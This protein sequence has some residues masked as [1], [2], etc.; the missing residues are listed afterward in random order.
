MPLTALEKA[1]NKAAQLVRN[2]AH[3]AR[4]R[5]LEKAVED[6]ERSPEVQA[7]RA[8]FDD[9]DA[10]QTA[11]DSR[12]DEQIAGIQEQIAQLQAQIQSLRSDAARI[13]LRE[14]RSDAADA[15]RKVKGGKVAT[16][17]ALFPDLVGAARWS[18]PACRRH[19]LAPDSTGRVAPLKP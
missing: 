17:E 13:A 16:A 1:Q 11:D 2:R 8:A 9:L 7:A 15:W 4:C 14:R 18:A 12:C 3:V 10:L 5:Q 19:R 6:A